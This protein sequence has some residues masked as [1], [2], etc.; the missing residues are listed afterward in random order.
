MTKQ[1]R[2]LAFPNLYEHRVSPFQLADPTRPGHRKILV[3]FLVDPHVHIP[4]ATDVCPQQEPWLRRAV[5][6]TALWERLPP[7][8]HEM[9]WEALDPITREQAEGYREELMKERTQV[10]KTVDGQRFGQ[11][12]NLWC[13]C[14]GCFGMF[15]PDPSV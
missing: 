8:L 15:V 11:M 1:D 9:V 7:E 14:T 12:F 4:S 2:C 6:G 13:V 5:E 3:L 10:V